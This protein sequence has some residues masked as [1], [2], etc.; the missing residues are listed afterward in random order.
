MTTPTV[1]E[2]NKARNNLYIL[3]R[4]AKFGTRHSRCKKIGRVKA[5]T[6]DS[7]KELTSP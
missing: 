4:R 6:A 2:L 7:N 1:E 5:Q 3:G